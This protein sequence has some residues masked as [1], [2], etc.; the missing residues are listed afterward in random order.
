MAHKD[1]DVRE[2]GLA[3]LYDMEYNIMILIAIENVET[4]DYGSNQ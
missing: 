1:E 2:I 4:A 3:M